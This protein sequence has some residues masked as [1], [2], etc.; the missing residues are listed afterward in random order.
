MARREINLSTTGTQSP[1]VLEDLGGRSFTHPTTD[2]NL[3]NEY[4]TDKLAKSDDLQGAIDSGYITLR[5]ENNVLLNSVEFLN[6][7][8]NFVAADPTANDD[9]DDGYSIGSR[10]INTT[11]N[12]LWYCA[13]NTVGSAVWIQPLTDANLQGVPSFSGS[14]FDSS[15]P[16]L[17]YNNTSWKVAMRFPYEGT[18]TIALSKVVIIASR[19]GTSGSSEFRIYDLTNGNQISY[20]SWSAAAITRYEDTTLVN[21]PANSAIFEV[22][23]KKDAGGS[24]K[25]RLHSLMVY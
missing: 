12:K 25:T 16:Y 17:E 20:V 18:N 10:W 4:G 15:T 13:D 2:F 21:L 6:I 22:Q 24:S 3:L 7:L 11:N 23:L 14:F 8:H 19:S 9:A 1:V 5:D